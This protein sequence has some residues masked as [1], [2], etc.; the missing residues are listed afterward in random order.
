MGVCRNNRSDGKPIQLHLPPHWIFY[1]K[2]SGKSLIY[3][4]MFRFYSGLQGL[5]RFFSIGICRD[6]LHFG[7]VM[8]PRRREHE[9]RRLMPKGDDGSQVWERSSRW[10]QTLR[11]SSASWPDRSLQLQ[12]SP[13]DSILNSKDQ[14]GCSLQWLRVPGCGSH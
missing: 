13:L 2:L 3:Y 5:L 9:G 8:W 12:R 14:L 11:K 4:Y 7:N 6:G 1:W 10:G